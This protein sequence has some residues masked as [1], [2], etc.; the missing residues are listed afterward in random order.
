MATTV[1]ALWTSDWP[2]LHGMGRVTRRV[3]R[4]RFD[5]REDPPR[6]VTHPDTV[7][8]EEPL[9]I[10][11]DGVPVTTTMRTPGDDFDL[12]LGHLVTEG[13]VDDPADVAAM[14]HCTDVD[15]DGQPTFNVVELTLRPGAALRHAPAARTEVTTSACGV[16]GK[17]SIEDALARVGSGV[18]DDDTTLPAA[19]IPGLVAA[20]RAR[21]AVFDRTGG[22]HAA[23]LF[24]PEPERPCLVV[25]EDVGRHNTVDKVVGWAAR[26]GRLPLRGHVLVVSS[27]AGFEIVQKAVA[28]GI[29]LA[30]AVGAATSLAV[31]LARESGLTLVGFARE[32]SLAAYSRPDRLTTRPGAVGADTVQ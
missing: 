17:Q 21:Q 1:D 23:A 3:P 19:G 11:V 18:H 27:R 13:L 14:M 4:T 2:T 32:D 5:L 8:V 6:V 15:A 26:E 31:E 28:A 22:L 25:R 9:E 7:V 24:G 20:L 16:C 12:A 10:R 30:A 29:P